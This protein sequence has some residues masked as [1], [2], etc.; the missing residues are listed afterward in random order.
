MLFFLPLLQHRLKQALNFKYQS[1]DQTAN[2][3]IWNFDKFWLNTTTE[4]K[5]SLSPQCLRNKFA[6]YISVT[7]ILQKKEK[8][9]L[10]RAFHSHSDKKMFWVSL[11]MVSHVSPW[12]ILYTVFLHSEPFICIFPH[13]CSSVQ[14]ITVPPRWQESHLTW[15]DLQAYICLRFA[16]L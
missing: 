12:R 5:L 1:S 6:R 14:V 2:I 13:S 15:P 10:S 4:R 8:K 11:V 16:V 7:P 3:L 9:R